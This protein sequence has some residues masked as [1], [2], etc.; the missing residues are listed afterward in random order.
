MIGK[1]SKYT[2]KAVAALTVAAGVSLLAFSAS[3]Q[4][5]EQ[6]YKGKTIRVMSTT[7]AG[8][9]MDLYLLLMMKHM[10]KHLPEG[11]ELVLEHRPGAGT[12]LGTNHLFN[13][14]PRDGS[15]FGMLGPGFAIVPFAYPEE[16]R[17]K[18]LEFIQIGRL[19]D[20]PRVF[21]AR[22]DSGITTIEDAK[23]IEATHAVL[24]P[25]DLTDMMMTL[26]NQTLDTR[27][28]RI[29]GYNGGGPAFLA[30][31]QG[32]V[33]STT[34][35][36]GNL[37][38][39]KWHLVEDGTVK[40]LAQFGLAPVPGLDGVPMVTEMVPADHPLH[41]AVQATAATAAHGLSVSFP[42]EVPQDRVDYL[43]EVLAKTMAD[44]ELLAEA[45][46]RKIL[47][48]YA[49]GPDLEK[50]A[51]TAVEQPDAVKAWFF[52]LAQSAKK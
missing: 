25:G 18:P 1:F 50:A 20:L 36:P 3:A 19:V 47:I 39:N 24:N 16:A 41:G 34:A 52:E 30:M 9:T 21:V 40:V 2:R 14:A 23:T 45:K 22:A 46:E 13:A 27:F 29:P 6:F 33:Q 31:E 42:P 37:M 38:A 48:N 4:D 32:E 5:A 44:P 49:S 51:A 17:W 10:T 7:G 15:Y 26:V 12:I 11:A 43:R 28:K 8:G 35:E